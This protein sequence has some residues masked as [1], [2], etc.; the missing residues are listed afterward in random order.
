MK[1]KILLVLALCALLSACA[2]GG[3]AELPPYEVKYS[4]VVVLPEYKVKSLPFVTLE[5]RVDYSSWPIY[6]KEIV[7]LPPAHIKPVYMRY[8][9]QPETEL[10]HA[11]L[12]QLEAY[13]CLVREFP[14]YSPPY[15]YFPACYSLYDVDEDG[16]PELIV[17]SNGYGLNRYVEVFTFRDGQ[18]VLLGLIYVGS[19]AVLQTWPGKNAMLYIYGRM[20]QWSF[21]EWRIENGELEYETFAEGYT[22]NYP[23]Y[24]SGEDYVPGS[25]PLVWYSIGLDLPVMEYGVERSAEPLQY[26][27]ELRTR[28]ESTVRE[29]GTVYGVDR[30]PVDGLELIVWNEEDTGLVSFDKLCF[31]YGDDTCGPLSF[32]SALWADVNGD[33][34]EEYVLWNGYDDCL[35]LSLQND[36][37]YAYYIYSVGDRLTVYSDGTFLCEWDYDWYDEPY[38]N[39][40]AFRLSFDRDECYTAEQFEGEN[41]RSFADSSAVPVEWQAFEP[42]EQ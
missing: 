36:V 10:Q 38:T 8:K 14:Q 27:G 29:N 6:K 40:R 5:C 3:E 13:R 21:T 18:S 7:E 30:G 25:Q 32:T 2:P 20:G 19:G 39:I 11:Y 35:V 28:L 17:L 1:R 31:L 33:G 41:A 23:I 4:P 9:P 37:V 34:R 26:D 16:T 24:P 15:I 12:E 22:E 42:P